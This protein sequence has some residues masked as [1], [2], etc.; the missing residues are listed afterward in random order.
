MSDSNVHRILSQ[1]LDA[2][3]SGDRDKAVLLYS[4]AVEM[5]LMI[6]D[7]DARARLNKFATQAIERA[8]KLKGIT[9]N[10]SVPVSSPNLSPTTSNPSRV[11]PVKSKVL[12]ISSK[13]Y[14][15]IHRFYN[16]FWFFYR[17]I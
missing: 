5:I 16:I 6:D 11:V 2:D 4:Q 10:A 8:E 9:Y 15:G 1:A 17:Y 14:N 12:C 7:K 3:E 13:K